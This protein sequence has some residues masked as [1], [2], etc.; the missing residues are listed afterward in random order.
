MFIIETIFL[1]LTICIDSIILC[2]LTEIDKKRYYFLIPFI[3]ST[4]QI[5][6]LFLGHSLGNLIESYLIN[7]LKYI[8]FFI[9]AFMGLKLLV[10]SLLNK[11]KEDNNL[12]SLRN[13]TIQATLTSFD[14]LFLGVPIAFNNNKYYISFAI[15]VAM[16]FILCLSSLLIRKNINK[17]H[18]DKF[19]LIGSIIL[20]IFAFKSLI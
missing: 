5:I 6:F 2:L 14:S 8:K 20:F 3:F 9:F 11:D 10:D 17:K 4:F 12:N 19:N 15:I 18:N 13:I 1:S 7:F 16:T